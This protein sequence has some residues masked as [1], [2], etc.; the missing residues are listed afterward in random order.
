[1]IGEMGSDSIKG[2]GFFSS[3]KRPDWIRGQLNIYPMGNGSSF[4][5]VRDVHHSLPTSVEEKNA[6]SYTP[7]PPCVF[8]AW[9]LS[10]GITLPFHPLR[11][12]F[13]DTNIHDF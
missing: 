13:I 9:Y 3:P 2:K 6:H 10:I 7:T 8:M 5:R 1:M 12:K 11:R 4:P